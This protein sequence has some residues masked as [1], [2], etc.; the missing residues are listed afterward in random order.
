MGRSGTSLGHTQQYL[1]S[2][3]VLPTLSLFDFC[4][5]IG[6][7]ILLLDFII[8]FSMLCQGIKPLISLSG[9][10]DYAHSAIACWTREIICCVS[11]V[12]ATYRVYNCDK[13]ELNGLMPR[14]GSSD[15]K[16]WSPVW[17]APPKD[18]AGYCTFTFTLKQ[19]D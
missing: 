10:C 8:A 12:S 5:H 19:S 4:D 2:R 11:V 17:P 6:T 13:G 7:G 14:F 15:I 18:T 1:G 3:P 9:V 16:I